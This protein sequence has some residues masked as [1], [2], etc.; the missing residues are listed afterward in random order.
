MQRGVQTYAEVCGGVS[1]QLIR[2]CG[3]VSL[4]LLRLHKWVSLQLITLHRG[5]CRGAQKCMEGCMVYAE[6][7][8][9]VHRVTCRYVEVGV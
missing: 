7:H 4:Q 5:V 1:L 6:V 3:G 2:S 8:G 9:G